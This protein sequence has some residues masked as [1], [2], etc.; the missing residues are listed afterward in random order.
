ML[1]DK[2]LSKSLTQLNEKL[3]SQLRAQ[4]Q[5]LNNLKHQLEDYKQELA[6]REKKYK[7]EL[8]KLNK[9]IASQKDFSQDN[10]NLKQKLDALKADIEGL[11]LAKEKA[12]EGLTQLAYGLGTQLEYLNKA[13]E[14]G[15]TAKAKEYIV[16][17]EVNDPSKSLLKNYRPYYENLQSRVKSVQ[18]LEGLVKREE[19]T[20]KQEKA[21]FHSER[22]QYTLALELQDY[23]VKEKVLNH[24]ETPDTAIAKLSG[25]IAPMARFLARFSLWFRGA[26]LGA[27]TIFICLN[28]INP[29]KYLFL[30]EEEKRRIKLDSD[31]FVT[32]PHI[33]SM[34]MDSESSTNLNYFEKVKL[35]LSDLTIS[36]I[37]D[38]SKIRIFKELAP[39]SQELDVDQAKEV[40][41]LGSEQ[42]RNIDEQARELEEVDTRQFETLAELDPSK[43]NQNIITLVQQIRE[44]AGI[45]VAR[46]EVNIEALNSSELTNMRIFVNNQPISLIDF[47]QLNNLALELQKDINKF[48]RLGVPKSDNIE[49]YKTSFAQI[50]TSYED[51]LTLVNQLVQPNP[52]LVQEN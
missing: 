46:V 28:F 51:L 15:D 33:F 9:Q 21:K 12:R 22:Q 45:A 44:L 2:T 5:V 14:A 41:K 39:E 6:S 20:L 13:L 31:S 3:E 37:K 34:S 47:I 11:Y 26:I 43:L 38:V 1:E 27:F 42:E 19:N 7:D 10:K 24:N 16:S 23:L 50:E 29:L 36:G 18:N 35:Q 48:N 40:E 4:K 52:T 25:A 8:E 32:L 30:N 17:F 49:V